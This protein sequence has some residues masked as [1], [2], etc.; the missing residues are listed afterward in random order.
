MDY[1]LTEM[2]E[3]QAFR[4]F[5]VIYSLFKSVRLS[6]VIKLN[7]HKTLMR[8][9]MTY[10]CPACGL[11]AGTYLLKLQNSQKRISASLETLQVCHGFQF[12]V[13]I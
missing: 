2:V 10:A 11:A 13:R 7:L 3:A 6:A 1:K 5:I 4:T 9:V 12:S 8:S